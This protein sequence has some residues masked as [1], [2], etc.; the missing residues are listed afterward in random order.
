MGL[1]VIIAATGAVSVLGSF[2]GNR[3]SDQETEATFIA[4]Q[5]IEASRSLKNQG[6]NDPF[7]AT[8]CS[9]G[10]GIDSSGGSWT[11]SGSSNTIGDFTR[12][13]TVASVQRDGNGDIVASGG[14]DDPDTKQVTTDVTWNFSPT[15]QNTVTLITYLTNFVR[16]V[17]S[18]SN[19]LGQLD[20]SGNFDA[21]KVAISGNYAF[22]LRDNTSTNFLVI[23]ISDP[24]NLS[25][26]TSISLSG[27]PRNIAI[28]G[29]YAYVASGDNNQ[30]LQIIDISTPTSPSQV[31]SLNLS[32][33]QDALGVY[34]VGSTVYLSR[35]SGPQQELYIINATV[36]AAPVLLG[37]F[38]L[39]ANANEVI[40][41]GNY[42]YVATDDNSAELRVVNVT[43]PA[44]PISAGSLDLTGNDNGQTITGSGSTV[45]LGRSGSGGLAIIN[46]STPTSPSLTTTY[47]SG[48]AINDVH[49]DSGLSYTFLATSETTSELQVVDVSTPASPTQ[50]GSYDGD[51]SLLG[52]SYSSGLQALIAVGSSNSLEVI[53][54]GE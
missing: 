11:W 26:A 36:P 50:V 22:V 12:T 27:T 38:E 16:S 9:G 32:A 25:L 30:E 33:N 39:G 7:L 5:G 34:A 2:S 46:V 20:L 23:N 28:S 6:W 29:N 21:S 15:R 4:Q 45:Y 10:C 51:G 44:V 43:V 14:T 47:S 17:G 53:S 48:G 8:D 24:S 52:I 41:I 13:I 31:G 1:F 42:A 54:I 35:A 37:S 49:Y 40:T 18:W 3:L 19:L